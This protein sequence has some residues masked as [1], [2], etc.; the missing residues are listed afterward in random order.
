M[1][2]PPQNRLRRALGATLAVAAL[3][4]MA[5][6]ASA[7]T[8]GTIVGLVTDGSSM[9]PLSGVRGLPAPAPDSGS[10]GVSSE[11]SGISTMRV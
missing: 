5:A 3:L 6:T 9:A 11:P 7:Q 4:L 2:G 1:S 8:T 10:G